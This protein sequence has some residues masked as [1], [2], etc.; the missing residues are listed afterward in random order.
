MADAGGRS[1]RALR[2]D[3]ADNVAVAVTA[4]APGERIA[5][6]ELT[7]EVRDP[8]AF[9][10]KIALA[11]VEPGE[12]ILKYHEVIGRA[13][14][15]I[16]VGEHVHV[17][18]VVSARLPG[19]GDAIVATANGALTASERRGNHEFAIRRTHCPTPSHSRSGGA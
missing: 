19:P 4:L 11:A 9:G 13:A 8:V 3:P 1:V 6:G 7:V 10:H 5:V 2:L 15:P 12:A 17:H 16:A 14:T 18:N